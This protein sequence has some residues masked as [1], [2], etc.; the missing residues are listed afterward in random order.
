MSVLIIS[1]PVGPIG[2][3]LGG[4]VELT[5]RNIAHGLELLG[6]HV[7]V[8]APAGSATV[9]SATHCVDGE[10]EP[11]VQFVE[12]S[13]PISEPRR[14]AVLT[15]MW[16]YVCEHASEHDVVLNMAYDALPFHDGA[17]LPVPIAH[18]VSM[19][20][21]TDAMDFVIDGVLVAQPSTVAMH[22][23]AQAST[24]P[25]G[26]NAT[27]VG[28]G[29]DLD[30]YVFRSECSP[31]GRLAF[32]G[33]IAPEKGLA[34]AIEVAAATGRPLHVWG[35]MQDEDLWQSSLAQ[36]PDADVHYRGFVST[37]V[38][39]DGLGE[40]AGLVMTPKWVEAFGNVAIEAL[41]CG[42]PVV[43]YDRGGPAEIVVDGAT[44]FL[45]PPDDPVALARA[46]GRLG[47]INRAD[48]R[49]RAEAE[50]STPAFARRV[51]NWLAGSLAGADFGGMPLSF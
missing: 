2:S 10:I 26:A 37:E 11:S 23:R 35:Y 33:R 51:E 29:I 18:L 14:E 42:V 41:A 25:H 13:S 44:G 5:I 8:V 22:S 20:S 45:V 38:L 40:C 31:D 24:F 16:S 47:V 21:L 36:F 39:Q 15:R 46:V 4:G 48:C 3:G 49:A 1:T 32:I 34:D 30:R 17:S 9:G 50:F 6:H 7:E 19:G 28:S 27:I 43:A 12:R